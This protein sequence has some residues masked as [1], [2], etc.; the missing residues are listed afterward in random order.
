MTKVDRQKGY[1][2]AH[3]RAVKAFA[4]EQ[5]V[6]KGS[7]MVVLTELLR[8]RNYKT[9]TSFR[10]RE[11]LV[12]DTGYCEKTVKWAM[13][14]LRETGIIIPAA[15]E[16][17]GRGCATIYKFRGNS[18]KGGENDTPYEAAPK[19]GGS[20][21]PKGGKKLPERGEKITP[22]TLRHKN[23]KEVEDAPRG[24]DGNPERVPLGE[25]REVA[26]S[27]LIQTLKEHGVETEGLSY[28]EV[29]AEIQKLGYQIVRQKD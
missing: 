20:F 3:E 11:D 24:E 27:Q 6:K 10:S 12:E 18:Q 25:H 22:P 17:G 14:H 21:L 2:R 1:V 9:L 28:S 15:Y 7:A 16:H 23:N 5:G 4:R 8:W 13:A 26:S 19:K 29:R